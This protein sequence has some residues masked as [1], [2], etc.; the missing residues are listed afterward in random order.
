[1]GEKVLKI[2]IFPENLTKKWE[3]VGFWSLE[4]HV[5]NYS[6]QE[7]LKY[8]QLPF[9]NSWANENAVWTLYVVLTPF[10]LR[11]E[12]MTITE[13]MVE[14]NRVVIFDDHVVIVYFLVRDDHANQLLARLDRHEII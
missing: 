12:D 10:T 9:Q 11:K 8:E 7:Q 6:A 13:S 1:M 5:S 3:K 4:I 2:A 14:P